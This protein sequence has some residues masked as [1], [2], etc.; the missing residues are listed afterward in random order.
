MDLGARLSPS[1]NV[2]VDVDDVAGGSVAVAATTIIIQ[3]Q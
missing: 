3:Q 1:H 2:D